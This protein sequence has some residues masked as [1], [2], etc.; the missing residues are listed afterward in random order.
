M[1]PPIYI[2]FFVKCYKGIY[3]MGIDYSRQC[4]GM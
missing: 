3:W 4:F 1:T 2:I